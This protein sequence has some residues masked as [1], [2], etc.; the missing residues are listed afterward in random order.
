MKK[1]CFFSGDI[2]RS[3]G[4]ERVGIMIANGLLE[5]GFNITII[6]LEEKRETPF[7]FI[8]ESI[9]RYVIKCNNKKNYFTIINK[10]LKIIKKNEIDIL[11]DIDGIL[12]IY[13][14]P[15]KLFSRVKVISWEHFNFY[16]T[17]GNRLRKPIRKL[18]GRYADKIITLTEQDTKFYK[19]NLNLKSQIDYIYNPIS[20]NY[21]YDHDLNAKT[22][23]SVGRLTYQKGFD[24]LVEVAK[25]ILVKHNDWKWI[26][27]GEG[28]DRELLESKINEYK[29]KDRLILQGNVK[30]VDDYYIKSSFFVLTSRFEGLPM[31]LLEAK[32]YKLP[33][34]SF[35][36]KTGPSELIINNVN[37]YLI[38]EFDLLELEKKI[39]KLIENQNILEEFTENSLINLEKFSYNKIISKWERTLNDL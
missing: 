8:N 36:C 28:E 30:N 5:R 31:T 18:A 26:I 22:I 13:S 27:L 19:D 12:D 32:K 38:K 20:N 33:I 16:Q 11:I 6:S 15:C 9:N 7:F 17:L 2:T 34:I 4:T 21:I 39:N 29:L 23:I 1:I 10:L 35:D 14:L 24:M 37:G 25:N 3:G